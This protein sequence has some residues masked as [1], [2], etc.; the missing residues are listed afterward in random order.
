MSL[1]ATVVIKKKRGVGKK[2][3]D[4]MWTIFDSIEQ[5]YGVSAEEL[6]TKYLT[7][8]DPD[9]DLGRCQGFCK[10][11]KPCPFKARM[12]CNGFCKKHKDFSEKVLAGMRGYQQQLDAELP[13]DDTDSDLNNILHRCSVNSDASSS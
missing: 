13:E 7:N 11:Y 5:D 3:Q 8:Y 6:K 2:L 1:S 12:G 10:G 9:K 4:V